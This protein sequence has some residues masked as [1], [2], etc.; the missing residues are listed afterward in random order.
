MAR[1]IR[2]ARLVSLIQG[3]VYHSG[4]RQNQGIDVKKPTELKWNSTGWLL[5]NL[6]GIF[7]FSKLGWESSAAGDA[8]AAVCFVLLALAQCGTVLG[9]WL[10]RK[11]LTAAQATIYHLLLISFATAFAV[12]Y[13]WQTELALSDQTLV[14][15]ERLPWIVG[16][17]VV[18]VFSLIG[19]FKWREAKWHAYQAEQEA[20]KEAAET[21]TASSPSP[22]PTPTEG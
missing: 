12:I 13:V 9:F 10:R 8:F 11:T 14:D 18:L 4:T 1:L 6:G 2:P 5:G 3:E 7:L 19:W 22:V 16:V 17:V 21:A 20:G 15:L